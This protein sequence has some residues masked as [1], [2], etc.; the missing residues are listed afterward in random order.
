VRGRLRY[1]AQRKKKQN[2]NWLFDGTSNRAESPVVLLIF[3]VGN[4]NS[5]R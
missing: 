2:Q 3:R 5:R 1:V 4:N